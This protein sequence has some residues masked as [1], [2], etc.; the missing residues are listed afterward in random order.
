VDELRPARAAGRE[1][2]VDVVLALQNT[3][4]AELALGGVRAPVEVLRPPAV[5]FDLLVDVTDDYR[6]SGTP[7]G[8][9]VTVEYRVEVFPAA[10]MRW[11]A[12]ALLCVLEAMAASMISEPDSRIGQLAGV[13]DLPPDTPPAALPDT[14]PP[15]AA[16][17]GHRTPGTDLE[18]RLAAIWADVLGVERVGADDDFFALGGNSLRAVRAAARIATA[19]RLPVTAAHILAAPTV[20][21]LA[22]RV[23]GEPTAPQPRIPRLPRIPRPVPDGG[24]A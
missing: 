23:A 13:P 1:P 22:R 21:Q 10:V 6:P 15:P 18:R 5:R 16:A 20:A 7:D 17:A 4:R 12:D 2:L 14:G 3:D 19:E 9:T 11:L 8:I 24:E